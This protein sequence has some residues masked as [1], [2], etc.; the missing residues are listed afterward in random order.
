VMTAEA[1]ATAVATTT[2]RA[3]TENLAVFVIRPV[4]G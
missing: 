4:H 1:V 3:T 2:V